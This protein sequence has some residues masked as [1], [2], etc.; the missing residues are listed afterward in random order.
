MRHITHKI[1][2]NSLKSFS[3]QVSEDTPQFLMDGFINW[4]SNYIAD[5]AQFEDGH[6][7][8]FGWSQILC[9]VVGNELTLIAPNYKDMPI[10]WTTD[11]NIVAA[12]KF[13]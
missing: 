6:T 13:P 5:G 1:E 11:P 3:F 2:N 10:K 12:H 8:E 9:Q 4:L 7:L